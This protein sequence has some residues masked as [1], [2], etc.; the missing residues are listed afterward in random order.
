MAMA[1]Q[2]TWNTN[3]FAAVADAAAHVNRIKIG[4]CLSRAQQELCLQLS[5]DI[6]IKRCPLLI[7][8][9][10]ASQTAKWLNGQMTL[11][12]SSLRIGHNY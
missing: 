10:A 8:L 6:A 4:H 11:S 5:S 1:K 3:L 9:A 12:Q 2:K 7:Y